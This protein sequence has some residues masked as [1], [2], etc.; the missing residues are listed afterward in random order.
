MEPTDKVRWIYS[1]REN[2]KLADR[3]DQLSREYDQDPVD[4]Y[5]HNRLNK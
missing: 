4:I 5:K 2:R 1:S 3:H